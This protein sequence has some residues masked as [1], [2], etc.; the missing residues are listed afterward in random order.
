LR[1]R[2]PRRPTPL[3]LALSRAVVLG[4]SPDARRVLHWTGSGAAATTAGLASLFGDAVAVDAASGVAALERQSRDFDL[5]VADL[6]GRARVRRA[7]LERFAHAL[8]GALRPDGMALVRV[9]A[10]GP[11]AR[12]AHRWR[13]TG[14]A[15]VRALRRALTEEGA[16]VIW[17][18][19]DAEGALW[20]YA[21]ARPRHLSLVRGTPLDS[22]EVP[23]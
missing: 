22:P 21:V 6:T 13:G 19:E 11:A 20:L 5:A 16:E 18:G 10:P 1:R 23:H 14:S 12:V 4:L 15:E 8:A 2:P 7:D 3:D 9:P 17:A